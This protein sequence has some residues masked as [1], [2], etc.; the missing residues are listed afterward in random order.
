MTWQ[1]PLAPDELHAAVRREPIVLG[2]SLERSLRPNVELWREALPSSIALRDVVARRG[3]R[4]LTCSAEKRTRPRLLMARQCGVPAH[5][6]L[7]HV[8]DTDAKFA[9]W[10]L[11]EAAGCEISQFGDLAELDV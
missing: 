11:R 10:L 3:L 6:V 9:D 1:V 4:W 8:R 7:S 5:A 2:S